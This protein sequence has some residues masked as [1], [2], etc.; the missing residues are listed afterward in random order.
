MFPFDGTKCTLESI[1]IFL[2]NP[3]SFVLLHDDEELS[4]FKVENPGKQVVSWN[5]FSNLPI[6]LTMLEL[7]CR[8][9]SKSTVH[10]LEINM[11]I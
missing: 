4:K 6:D 11:R 2:D 9:N 1:V 3:C 7:K 10:S 8:S 5:N